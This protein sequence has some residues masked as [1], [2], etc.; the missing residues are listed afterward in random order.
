MKKTFGSLRYLVLFFSFLM[1]SCF[2]LP[3][4]P[5]HAE[6]TPQLLN[7]GWSYR[8]LDASAKLSDNAGIL[9]QATS[10]TGWIKAANISDGISTNDKR[11][12]FL[13]KIILPAGNWVSPCLYIPS[14]VAQDINVYLD[15]KLIY[16]RVRTYNRNRNTLVLPLVKDITGKQLLFYVHVDDAT[17]IAGPTSNVTI[18]NHE[19]LMQTAMHFGFIDLILGSA[20][21]ITALIML[22]G[23][24][25]LIGSPRVTWIIL[26]LTIF[27][28]G[29][30][31]ASFN[32]NLA[33]I[34]PQ[35]DHILENLFGCAMYATIVLLLL[36]FARILGNSYKRKLGKY[37]AFQASF[38]IIALAIKFIND[39]YSNKFAS[40]TILVC[41]Q[42]TS[43]TFLIVLLILLIMSVFYSF[44]GN[45]EAKIFTFGFI[46]LALLTSLDLIF[47]LQTH[48]YTFT[49]WKWGVLAFVLS[50]ISIMA[51]R[52]ALDHR[53]AVAYSHELEVKNLRL[54]ELWTEV[55][56]SRDAIAQWNNELEKM[57]AERTASI[58]NLLNHAEQGFLYFKD[59]LLIKPEF[60]KACTDIFETDIAGENISQLLFPSNEKSRQHL[61]K[62]FSS[63]LHDE[64]E[65][66]KNV[67][68]SAMPHEFSL[69]GKIIKGDYKVIPAASGEENE[70]SVMMILTDITHNRIIE[71]QI[72]EERKV[73]KMI[74]N[75]VVNQDDFTSYM[76]E[77]RHLCRT[78]IDHI[79]EESN[80]SSAY[81]E[82]YRQIHTFKGNFSQFGLNEIVGRLHTL[83]TK[84]STL[85][86]APSQLTTEK[87]NA[88]LDRKVLESWLDEELKLIT[89]ILGEN[90]FDQ[91]SKLMIDESKLAMIEDKLNTLFPTEQCI[92][93]QKDLRRLRNKSLKSLLKLYPS[94]VDNLA[95]RLQKYIHPFEIS[96]ADIEVNPEHFHE[97]IKSLIHVFRNA[98]DHGI[99]S[100]DDRLEAGKDQYGCI[101]CNIRVNKANA[102]LSIADD[103]KG[104]SFDEIKAQCVKNSLYTQETVESMPAE[105]LLMIL[106][107]QGFTTRQNANETSGRGIGLAAVKT[108]LDKLNGSVTV[109][110][111]YGKGTAF[112]FSI[113][114]SE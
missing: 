62:A 6:Q 112:H 100:G 88:M 28:I 59:D 15:N 85:N 33:F 13:L 22:I 55:T 53:N 109:E 101:T 39:A 89:S 51:R 36:F 54:S 71:T 27:S 50:L 4:V 46:L 7:Q 12:D 74:V 26:C 25:F 72:E 114:L 8:W 37:V 2:I 10:T 18:G 83:E 90:Y 98:V 20:L 78:E 52:F 70:N 105:K 24:L 47:L 16:K 66:R 111:E 61:T 81:G 99:E 3:V 42:L 96:G 75:I 11:T 41:V 35:Y 84:L 1:L 44:K 43:L 49:F 102:I 5:V 113:P 19:K 97:F 108:A 103:G 31:I 106:F 104:I 21:I 79:L 65:Y 45:T 93:L 17:A 30:M 23:S 38:S 80:I 60:S 77:Y 92:E 56:A 76:E 57:I 107:D 32:S 110:T 48:L 34:Y 73:L 87:L 86:D 29:T 40:L 9:Q 69:S 68:I 82:I 63:I 14:F 94:Y 58:S 67:Y 95:V 91:K 64:D